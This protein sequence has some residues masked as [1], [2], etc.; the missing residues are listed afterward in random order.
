[1]IRKTASDDHHDVVAGLAP[2]LL[3]QI[4]TLHARHYARD[5][6]FGLFFEAKVAR[7]L[8]AFADRYAGHRDLTLSSWNRETG[9]LLGTITMDG[10]WSGGENG[11]GRN[12]GAH[13]RWFILAQEARGTGLGRHLLER[14]LA[15]ADEKRFPRVWLTTFRGLD[16]ARHL[17]ESTGFTLQSEQ[18][19][20]TWGTYV[21]EQV[22]ERKRP[23]N[24]SPAQT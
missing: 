19:D 5:W 13:L 21:T 12:G 22:F 8:A 10:G 24:P 2:G 16:A 18:G 9:A 14:A 20:S 11:V 6:G 15:F 4:V 7:D 3:G 23:A 1:M 17:Y